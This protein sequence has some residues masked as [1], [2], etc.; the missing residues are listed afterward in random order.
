MWRFGGQRLG[1]GG[2]RLPDQR[3]R[4]MPKSGRIR[5]EEGRSY[6]VA[7]KVRKKT[8]F[9]IGYNLSIVEDGKEVE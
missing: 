8:K 4:M 7:E 2:D 9:D 1:G 3:S 5:I 6:N